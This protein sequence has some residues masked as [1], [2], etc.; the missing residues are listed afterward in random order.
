M[1]RILVIRGGAIG[2]FILTLPA[3]RLIRDSIP[4]CRVEVLGYPG[5]VDLALAAGVADAV[6]NLE[7]R[8]M[9]MLFAPGAKI[10]DTLADW[11][12]SFNLI[13]SYLYDP[14]GHLRGNMESLGVRTYLDVPHQVR[15]G[16]GTAAAQ[17]AKPLERLAM[18][19]ED[20]AP[21]IRVP[22]ALPANGCIA[23]HIGSGSLKKNWS[24][25]HWS[26]VGHELAAAG[27]RLVL[28]TGEA[29][30]ERGHTAAITA[31]WSGLDYDHWDC[32]PLTELARRL[33]SCAQFLGHDSGVSHLAAACGV[34][35]HLFFG[36]TDPATWAPAHPHVRVHRASG[37]DV[38]AMSW[39][40]GWTA[41]N[42]IV[43]A[44]QKGAN[45]S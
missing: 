8:R 2:D 22:D 4:L 20:P 32:L 43:G 15:D 42:A 34:A 28:I 27:Q 24:I 3:I 45:P 18:F 11:L 33:P 9:A 41:L 12:R 31:A 29:E 10:D 6:Q 37:A 7:H 16:A 35:C 19:L 5:I 13:V 38:N 26:R 14:D 44:P 40:E 23:I 1:S 36:P 25:A 21:R 17:L 39:E 30:L